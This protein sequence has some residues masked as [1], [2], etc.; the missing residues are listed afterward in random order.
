[1]PAASDQ[2][3]GSYLAHV[4]I[5]ALRP[6]DIKDA[7]DVLARGMRDNPNHVASFGV[8]RA[9]RLV[10]LGS[11]LENL[12]SIAAWQTLVARDVKGTIV[13]VMAVTG[14]GECRV[15]P[16]HG[17]RALPSSWLGD[18]EV[19]PRVA[20]W[21]EAWRERDPEERHW[22]VGPLAVEKHL[23]GKGI[24]SGLLRVLCAQMD[25]GKENAYLETDL[26]EN[27]SFCERFGFEVVGEHPV[28]GAA[29]W[30]MIRRPRLGGGDSETGV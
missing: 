1:M 16:L 17:P 7:M 6:R 28:L 25:A 18:P 5:G 22:H 21:L 14:P 15:S 12:K 4:E 9:L 19:A 20:Q 29:N 30:F 8:D 23:Q 13:G 3:D 24:G 10:R 26:R 11:F 2:R 27:V